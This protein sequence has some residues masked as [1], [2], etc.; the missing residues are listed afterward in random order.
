MGRGGESASFPAPPLDNPSRKPVIYNISSIRIE[1][2]NSRQ[3]ETGWELEQVSVMNM[4]VPIIGRYLPIQELHF[5]ITVNTKDRV[6][7]KSL[8]PR[9]KKSLNRFHS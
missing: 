3:T 9:D 6:I 5:Y 1:K 7:T 2:I 8:Q 4:P